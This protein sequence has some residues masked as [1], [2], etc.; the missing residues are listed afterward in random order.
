[1][2]RLTGR[3]SL[4]AVHAPAGAASGRL[5]RA[6]HTSQ[7]SWSSSAHDT[8]VSSD[9]ATFKMAPRIRRFSLGPAR[10]NAQAS[11]A[12]A[13]MFRSRSNVRFPIHVET[14]D[15]IDAERWLSVPAGRR[16]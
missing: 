6:L 4:F 14:N 13:L 16:S 1:M 2:R 12:T 5:T 8:R 10:L 7:V 15:D 3:H 11:I 9:H